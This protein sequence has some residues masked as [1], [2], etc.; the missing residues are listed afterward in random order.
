MGGEIQLGAEWNLTQEHQGCGGN[1][2]EGGNQ[3]VP[4]P[5]IC[6]LGSVGQGSEFPRQ[7]Q[8]FVLCKEREKPQELHQ[9]MPPVSARQ[10]KCPQCQH[11]KAKE[12]GK[13]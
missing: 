7:T 6:V 11:D 1:P 8:S 13:D 12:P 9:E 4:A 2:R 10:G 5:G 3:G